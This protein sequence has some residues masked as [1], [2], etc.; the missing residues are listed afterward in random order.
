MAE[1]AGRS[2][3][4][5]DASSELNARPLKRGRRAREAQRSLCDWMCLQFS[6]KVG[7]PFFSAKLIKKGSRL[8]HTQCWFWGQDIR[9]PAGNLLVQY[10]FERFRPPE[11]VEGSSAY[12][13]ALVPARETSCLILWGFGLFYGTEG[14][15]G[16]FLDRFRFLPRWTPQHLL[17]LPLWRKDQLPD[18]SVPEEASRLV[19]AARMC[20]RLCAWIEAY[21][22]WVNGLMGTS[23]HARCLKSFPQAT[24]SLTEHLQGWRDLHEAMSAMAVGSNTYPLL[25]QIHSR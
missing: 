25:N 3:S 24:H 20:A 23:Y 15:G 5:G 9:S 14:A 12:L 2:S 13:L 17:K 18:A 8:L 19:V 22:R 16:I 10:G 6:R 1:G 11:G 4:A 7:G 21:E